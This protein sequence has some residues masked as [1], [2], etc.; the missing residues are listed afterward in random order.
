M[1]SH[2]ARIVEAILF[3]ENEALTIEKLAAMSNLSEKDCEKN[4]PTFHHQ[5]L[6]AKNVFGSFHRTCDRWRRHNI[7]HSF[8]IDDGGCE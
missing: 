7:S 3:I 8:G 6:H 5:F 2:E 4:F 1:L